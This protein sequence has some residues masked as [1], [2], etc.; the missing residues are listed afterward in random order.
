MKDR[1]TIEGERE[2]GVS[3]PDGNQ[4]EEKEMK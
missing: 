2:E 1:R 3:D 4:E